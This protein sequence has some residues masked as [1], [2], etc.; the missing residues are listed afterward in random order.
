[1]HLNSIHLLG[2]VVFNEGPLTRGVLNEPLSVLNEYPRGLSIGLLLGTPLGHSVK[3]IGN[4]SKCR[5]T[6]DRLN[7]LPTT[8]PT[9]L[10]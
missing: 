1:M 6:S 2:G 7:A 3:E 8:L 9:L 10:I 5:T 4:V